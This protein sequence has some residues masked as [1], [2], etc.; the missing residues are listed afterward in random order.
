MAAIQ[1]IDRGNGGA[2]GIGSAFGGGFGQ[3][4]GQGLSGGL[5]T[6]LQNKLNQKLEKIERKETY[7]SLQ[8]LGFAPE[9]AMGIASLPSDLRKYF[10]QQI[11]ERPAPMNQ[12]IQQPQVPEVPQIQNQT[13]QLPSSALSQQRQLPQI[14]PSELIPQAAGSLLQQPLQQE[15]QK[16]SPQQEKKSVAEESAQRQTQLP[17]DTKPEQ[18]TNLPA[19]PTIREVLAGPTKKQIALEKKEDQRRQ[20]AL[21]KQE[22]A[23]Q[24]HI[25]KETK[26]TYD[27]IS[28]DGNAAKTNNMRLDRMDYLIDKGNLS[29][30]LFSSVYKTLSDGIFGIGIDIP[31]IITADT[32]EFNKLSHDFIRSAKD[33][34]GSRITNADLNA[35]L[36]TVPTITQTEQGK[37]A[38]INNLRQMNQLPLLRK[39]AMNRIIAENG[40]VRPRHLDT[41]VEQ[42]IA[43]YLDEIAERFKQGGLAYPS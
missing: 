18:I 21:Q 1:V 6:L 8:S 12:G 3:G 14:N 4:L 23:E 22:R 29:N 39:E 2:A 13:A 25:D 17:P 26:A 28:K 16:L 27:A 40:G 31:F 37:R 36:K 10:I 11:S 42:E 20:D 32:Q 19:K 30:S 38:V 7:N 24:H 33:I 35:F 15:I 5:Q 41:L 43:P 34:F 9:E